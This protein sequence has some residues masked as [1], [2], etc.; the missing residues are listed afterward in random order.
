[1]S[2]NRTE[3]YMIHRFIIAVLLMIPIVLSI[4]T[5]YKLSTD[6][7]FPEKYYKV[8]AD[9]II[10]DKYRTNGG[11]AYV[12]VNG[13]AHYVNENVMS[14]YSKGQHV[15]L[16]ETNG[17]NGWHV[18]R[19]LLMFLVIFISLCCAVFFFIQLIELY[20]KWLKGELK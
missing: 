18:I 17:E 5:G 19:I 15:T 11:K 10:T 13:T 6:D 8:T 4:D 2:L 9:G 7:N 16:N 1:M 3:R 14:Q 12:V 20:F